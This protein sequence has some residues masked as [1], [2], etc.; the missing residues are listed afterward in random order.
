MTP[1]RVGAPRRDV[2]AV[3]GALGPKGAIWSTIISFSKRQPLGAGAAFVA[4][5]LIIV[6]IFAPWIATHDPRETNVLEFKFAGPG[7][8]LWLGG[9]QLGRD[10]FSRLVYGARISLLVGILSVVFGVTGGFVLGIVSAYFGGKTDLYLQRIM[11]A[12]IA[13]PAL[14]LALAI[15]AVLG[16]SIRNVIIA[17]TVVFIPGAA[18]TVRSE[19][20]RIKEMDYVLAARAVGA[21]HLRIMLRHIAPNCFAMYIVLATISLGWAIIVEA[22]L[23]F[24]GAGIPPDIPSWGGMLTVAT[25]QYVEVGPWLAV[26]P[27][28]AIFIVVVA[29]NLLGD[30]LR[31]VLDPRLRGTGT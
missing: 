29:W 3:L 17:M 1:E 31:D 22:S 13:F 15:M 8:E 24:L 7:L 18:R 14:I 11:D 23:S 9:D 20:L 27:G 30:S 28:L 25:Q 5:A 12:M 10:V 16:P 4:I 6:A 26:F 21:P 19:A 2:G